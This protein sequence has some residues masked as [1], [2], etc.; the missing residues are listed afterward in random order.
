MP[1]F[2][3]KPH[4]YTGKFPLQHTLKHAV[5]SVDAMLDWLASADQFP[6]NMFTRT[7]IFR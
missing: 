2:R 3:L 6:V 5:Y 4:R 7:N 1:R